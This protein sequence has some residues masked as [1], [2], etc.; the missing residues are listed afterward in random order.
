M[1]LGGMRKEL[2]ATAV[3][4]A[5]AVIGTPA[6][7]AR[8]Q[9]NLP[10][11]VG[12]FQGITGAPNIGGQSQP[13][14][15]GRPTTP[16]PAGLPGAQSSPGAVAPPSQP[17]VMMEPTDALFDAINRG[18]L[19]AARD[20]VNRGADMNGHNVLGMTPI[21]LSVDLGRNDITF[22]L[23]SNGAGPT[24]GP[25]PSATTA[26][27]SRHSAASKTLKQAARN[28][29]TRSGRSPPRLR[30][31]CRACSPEMAGTRFQ[32]PVSWAS[33]LAIDRRVVAGS[34]DW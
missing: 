2:C 16:P 15:T 11:S 34:L 3:L 17:T 33:I 10:P 6:G 1:V 28:K 27:E 13:T 26:S 8:A 23:L 4:L 32:R 5:G 25:P 18:D 30:S 24:N 21:Q 19:T 20:A 14:G 7:P 9:M 12:Q 22:L 29:P 31:R